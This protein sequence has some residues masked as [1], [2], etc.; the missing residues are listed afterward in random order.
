MYLVL[1]PGQ[2]EVI[3]T[4]N[5][6]GDIVTDLGAGLQ[7]GL[8]FAASGNLHPGTHVDVRTRARLGAALRRQERREPDRRDRLDRPDA[9]DA[10][11]AATRP[12]AVDA[13]I[14]SPSTART[15][16]ATLGRGRR[17]TG[18]ARGPGEVRFRVRRFSVG[19]AVA[20]GPLPR[21]PS[22]NR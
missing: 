22:A 3:V 20:A 21:M 2:F 8:G 12:R 6:F 18:N 9:R 17:G 14:A 10:R 15:A 19:F 4:N 5:L 13:A 1:D 7:G 16:A 11:P